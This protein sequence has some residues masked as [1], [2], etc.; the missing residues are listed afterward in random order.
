MI[1][2]YNHSAHHNPSPI[3]RFPDVAVVIKLEVSSHFHFKRICRLRVSA[4]T[5][6]D[7]RGFLMLWYQTILISPTWINVSD[8]QYWW[9]CKGSR[10]RT[11]SPRELFPSDIRLGSVHQI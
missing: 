9:R 6:S 4:P 5:P 1:R 11:G 3:P 7:L 8:V 10:R 2:F